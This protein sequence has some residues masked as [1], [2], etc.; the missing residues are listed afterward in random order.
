MEDALNDIINIL[1]SGGVFTFLGV[2][3]H[4]AVK[5]FVIFMVCKHPELSDEKVKYLTRL[6]SKDK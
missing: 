5:A 3:I 6:I 1:V 2:C 4:N